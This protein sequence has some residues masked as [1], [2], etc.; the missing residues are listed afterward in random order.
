MAFWII[1][2]TVTVLSYLQARRSLFQPLRVEVFKLQLQLLTRITSLFTR[3]GELRLREHF[4]LDKI[5]KM[6]TFLMMGAY[7]SFLAGEPV[8]PDE[9]Y[10][11]EL[12]SDAEGSM[13]ILHPDTLVELVGPPDPDAEESRQSAAPMDKWSATKPQRLVITRRF[14]ESVDELEEFLA[15]PLLPDGLREPIERLNEAVHKNLE[16]IQDAL[17]EA[18]AI[19]PSSYPTIESTGKSNLSWI[20]N[21][22][23]RHAVRLEPLATDLVEA[24]RNYFDTKSLGL[25]RRAERLNLN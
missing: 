21:I 16:A 6:N 25:Q 3:G 9:V 4:D 19:L 13:I 1:A 12:A 10:L 5:L 15:D 8:Q 22:W 17:G 7:V 2:A 14:H 20:S 18:A 23:N 11:G 24:T